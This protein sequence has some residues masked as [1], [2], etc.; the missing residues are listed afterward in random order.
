M[1]GKHVLIA[2]ALALAACS[3]NKQAVPVGGSRADGTVELAYEFG[4]LQQPVVDWTAAQY[5]AE[6]RCK[7]WGYTQAEKFGGERRQCAMPSGYSCALYQVTISYQ[8][9]GGKPVVQNQ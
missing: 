9:T 6:Q 3:V 8:C 2:F 5:E 4:E 1:I 7:A